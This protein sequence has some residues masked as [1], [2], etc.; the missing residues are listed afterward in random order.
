MVL[1]RFTELLS[2]LIYTTTFEYYDFGCAS[3]MAVLMLI[4]T[5]AFSTVYTRVMM[6][7]D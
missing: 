3:A 4:V 5:L 2:L 1:M 6:R 7:E